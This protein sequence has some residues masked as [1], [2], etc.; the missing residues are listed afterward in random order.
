MFTKNPDP[1]QGVTLEMMLK[2]MVEHHGWEYMA[3]AIKINCFHFDPSIKSSLS[4]LRKTP[5]ARTKVESLY[6][7]LLRQDKKKNTIEEKDISKDN[8]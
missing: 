5:W 1:L 7:Y 2:Y 3:S 8:D 4:F 6:V